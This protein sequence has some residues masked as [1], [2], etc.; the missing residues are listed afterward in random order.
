MNARTKATIQMGRLA[1]L[2]EQIRELETSA[3]DEQDLDL[4]ANL[5]SEQSR[6][7]SNL[8]MSPMRAAS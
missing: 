6:I 2:A 4:L 1:D 3:Q 5:R 7:H 8:G